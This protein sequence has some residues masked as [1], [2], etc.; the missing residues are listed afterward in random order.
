MS[1]AY[2]SVNIHLLDKALQR[3]HMP[4]CLVNTIIN[5]L[6]NHSNPVITN[7]DPFL[8]YEVQDDID[9]KKTIIFLFEAYIMIYLLAI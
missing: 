8:I 5:L 1:K 6:H 4:I 2:D 7:F 9:Q 3:I